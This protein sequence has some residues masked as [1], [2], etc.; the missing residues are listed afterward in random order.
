MASDNTKVVF[1]VSETEKVSLLVNSIKEYRAEYPKSVIEVVAHGA[2]VLRLANN[3]GLA[4]EIKQLINQGV[5]F[6]VCN[7]SIRKRDIPEGILIEGVH[8]LSH[9]GVAHVIE[10][11][12]K[13]YFYI[14]I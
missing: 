9:G 6:G 12:K 8:I 5:R 11:Q 13:G 3:S 2:A 1:H 4:D 7:I 14:R 10:L